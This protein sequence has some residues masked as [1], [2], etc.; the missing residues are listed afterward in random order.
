MNIILRNLLL[1]SGLIFANNVF[2]EEKEK[3]ESPETV[4]GT[5]LIS[6]EQAKVMHAKGVK[7]VDVRSS[8]Q[9]N[10]RHIPGAIH[11]YIKDE[12]KEENLLKHLKKDEPFIVY[13]NGS[14]CSLSSKAA[15]KAVAWGFTKI[16]Y[17]RDG[18]RAWRKDGNLL[19]YGDK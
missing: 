1:I 3:W 16:K 7:F 6:L 15:R 2:A 10:K 9:Y 13:C 8:R 18:F 4:D 11:L 19:E 17:Y 14:H 12:F 5:E